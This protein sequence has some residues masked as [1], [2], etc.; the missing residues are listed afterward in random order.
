MINGVVYYFKELKSSHYTCITAFRAICKKRYG[1]YDD[2]DD[3]KDGLMN[4]M[5][6]LL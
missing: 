2:D 5:E 3:W 4:T 6:T 1:Y